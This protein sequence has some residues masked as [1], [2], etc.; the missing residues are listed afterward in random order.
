MKGIIT[1]N[2]QFLHFGAFQTLDG[3]VFR[4]RIQEEIS[5]NKGGYLFCT[6]RHISSKKALKELLKHQEKN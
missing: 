5:L 3:F 6:K 2:K 4:I 1:A